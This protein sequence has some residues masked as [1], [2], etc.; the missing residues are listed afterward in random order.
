MTW[1]DWAIVLVLAVSVVGGF[2]QGFLRS[3]FSLGGLILGL[4]IA[5]WNY[6]RAAALL[7][8]M[9]HVEAVANAIGFILI[10]LLVMLVANLIG[11]LLSKAVQRLGL[12]CLDRLAGG[13]FGF[14]QGALLITIS[15]LV[16]VAFFPQAHWLAD[17]RLPKFFFGFLHLGARVSP[18]ELAERVRNG[19]QIMEQHAPDW[20]HPQSR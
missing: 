2:S 16:I 3:I 12:G 11:S 17:A 4:G 10:A 8:P 14:L 5:A 7:L 6:D 9:V 18:A 1:V 20:M 19:L 15:I 13:V